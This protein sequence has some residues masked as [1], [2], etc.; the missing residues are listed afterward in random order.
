MATEFPTQSYLPAVET[1]PLVERTIGQALAER[2]ARHPERLAVVGRSHDGTDQ[3][4]TYRELYDEALRTA[5]ALLRLA[6][7]GDFVA[8]WAPNVI[9]WPV[10]EYGAALAGVVL[11]AVNPVFRSKE[12]E[13]VLRNSGAVALIHADV[14]RDYGMAAVAADVSARV[15]SIRTVVSLSDR[16]RWQLAEG[17]NVDESTLGPFSRDSSAPAMLQ[18]TSGTTGE[19][20]GVL[21]RHRSLLNNAKLTVE[22]MGA[23]DGFVAIN[24]LP[25]FH[26]ASCVIGTLGPMWM[27]GTVV[28]INTFDPDVVLDIMEAEQATVLFFVPTVLGALLEAARSRESVRQLQGILGGAAVVPSSMIAAAKRVFG[29]SVHNVFG[30][31]ELSPV[32]TVVRPDDSPEDAAQT[33]GRPMLHTEIKVVEIVSGATVP[34]ESEGEICARG[35]SQMIEYLG[36]PID[37]AKAVDA[38]GWMHTGDLGMIDDRGYV[39]VTGR[40]KDLIIRG[41]DNIAPAEVESRLVE[42]DLVF[43]AAVVGIPDEKWGEVVA[44]VLILRGEPT[45]ELAA[46]LAKFC[47]S[48]MSPFKTPTMWLRATEYPMTVSGKVQKF[49]LRDQVVHGKYS[50]IR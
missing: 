35:Y 1:T 10:I 21:L 49:I 48:A 7:P 23:A 27:T 31:T 34:R 37:T 12:L 3:R 20:K 45:A 15:P 33:V 9:E 32:I 25:M 44:A 50:P 40:L 28:L 17:S 47:R 43:Q 8:L 38:D 4:L 19:P 36:K 22:A 6:A 29:A 14:S 18:Y 24:P 41:G 13:Y 42:H 5:G 16:S 46:E 11:V 30:Q 39:W 2:A 26:T